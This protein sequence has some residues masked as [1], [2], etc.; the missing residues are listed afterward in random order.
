M[1][2]FKKN[3]SQEMKNLLVQQ[4]DPPTEFSSY[5]E[6]AMKLHNNYKE[7]NKKSRTSTNQR[8]SYA[9]LPTFT[10]TAAP[11]QAVTTAIGVHP[12][13][14]DL[15][16]TRSRPLTAEE[17]A[18]RRREGLCNYCGEKGHLYA[19]CPKATIANVRKLQLQTSVTTPPSAPSS[20]YSPSPSPSPPPPSEN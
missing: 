5:L 17:K 16:N 8:H 11:A 2:L 10:V 18:R 4:I 20:V 15:S 12:G 19:T 13:P 7:A 1:I 9:P 6:L 14:M 3:M